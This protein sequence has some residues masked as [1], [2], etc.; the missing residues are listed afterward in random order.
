MWSLRIST[1]LLTMT[2][3]S[4][5]RDTQYSRMLLVLGAFIVFGVGVAVG[6]VFGVGPRV[7]IWILGFFGLV[8]LL[9]RTRL[10][11]T[12]DATGVRVDRAFVPW[13]CIDRVEVLEGEPMRVA[14]GPGAHPTDFI[15]LRDTAAGM[16]IWLDDATDPHRAWVVS[17]RDPQRLRT[18]LAAHDGI[19]A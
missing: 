18:A 8:V 7:V 3:E 16:R 5:Y 11:C 4:E 10:C 1:S 17:V 15:R 12:L 14:I 9:R 19:T 13:Q 2:S 6:A